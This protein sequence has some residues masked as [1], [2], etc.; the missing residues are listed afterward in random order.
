MRRVYYAFAIKCVSHPATLY[1]VAFVALVWWLKELVFV[2]RVW[3]A[4]V[5]TPV[6]E[7]GSFGFKVLAHA[8]MLTLLVCA[9]VGIVVL[10]LG[11]QLRHARFYAPAIAT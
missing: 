3:Q 5:S 7:L 2:A 4:F 1:A 6:G 11:R 10:Q 9:A 8:D